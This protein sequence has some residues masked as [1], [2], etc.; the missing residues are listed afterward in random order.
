MRPSYGTK[1]N[2]DLVEIMHITKLAKNAMI[3]IRLHVEYPLAA[4]FDFDIKAKVWQR[5]YGFHIPIHNDLTMEQ[6]Y[7]DFRR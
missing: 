4:I 3:Q 2:A 6:S 1:Q 5:F 7:M